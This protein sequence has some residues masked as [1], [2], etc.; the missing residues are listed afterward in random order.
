MV[1]CCFFM[2]NNRQSFHGEVLHK[3]NELQHLSKRIACI[4]QAVNITDKVLLGV[5]FGSLPLLTSFLVLNHMSTFASSS[6]L[7]VTSS[8]VS[9]ISLK[10]EQVHSETS[11]VIVIVSCHPECQI[12]PTDEIL[13]FGGSTFPLKHVTTCEEPS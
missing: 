12:I 1:S 11:E 5:L 6:V 10:Q 3:I 7:F 8:N 2:E 13:L 9:M 4:W